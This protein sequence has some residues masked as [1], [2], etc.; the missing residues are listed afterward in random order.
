MNENGQATMTLDDLRTVLESQGGVDVRELGE[1][2]EMC[3][4]GC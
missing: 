1:Y 2:A 3:W 4:T